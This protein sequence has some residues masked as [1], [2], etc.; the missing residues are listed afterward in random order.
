MLVETPNICHE[1]SINITNIA[2]AKKYIL[3]NNISYIKIG[4][5]DL[6]GILRGKIISKDK[7]FSILDNNGG[8]YDGILGSDIDDALIP[9]MDFTGEHTGYPD[10]KIKI[11]P[12]SAKV[13]P[14]EP[15]SIFFLCQFE[16]DAK[17]LCP[18]SLFQKIL[19][20]ADNMGFAIKSGMEFEFSVFKETSEQLRA[21]N[22]KNLTPLSEGNF[23]YSIRKNSAND[24]LCCDILESFKS[25]NIPLE[26]LHTEIGQ[27]MLEAAL[28][29]DSNINC[30]DNAALFKA[31]I[32][33]LLDRRA[34][35]SNFMAKYNADVQG[36]GAH[37]H[38]SLLDKISNKNTF[39][40]ASCSNNMSKT[41]QH[42][43]AGQQ[44]LMG[45]FLVLCAP[46]VNSYARYIPNCWA[47]TDAI[48]GF[49]NRAVSLRVIRGSEKSQRIEYRIPGADA[50]PYLAYAAA[51]ASGLYGIENK[52]ELRPAF[53]LNNPKFSKD[54]QL[55][56][57]LNSATKLFE[58]SNAAK[59]LFGEDFVKDYS[60]T[61]KWEVL[62]YQKAI[63]DWELQRYFE[64]T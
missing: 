39:F 18:R 61:K 47:P 30:A 34:L 9:N 58:N 63:T 37:I 16:D 1:K 31:F 17:K 3:D 14:W 64:N 7:F 22:F 60:E 5:F 11:I 45:E 26:C 51:L 50:N 6:H 15:N 19:D 27:G 57:D 4:L 25:M 43:I 29:V 23:G 59:D 48:W 24:Q 21:K 54:T 40:D 44:A 52:L 42:F 56:K 46:N 53:D 62:Q 12:E 2:Q 49:D 38:L 33:I 32:K 35:S 28:K 55:P 8:F 20:K 36:H 10:A 41:M 13:I